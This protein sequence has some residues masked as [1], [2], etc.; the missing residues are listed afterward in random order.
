MS[1][2]RKTFE[3]GIETLTSPLRACHNLPVRKTD[4]RPE[5]AA[6]RPHKKRFSN[7]VPKKS[8]KKRSPKKRR[9]QPPAVGTQV[10]PD[11]GGPA[12]PIDAKPPLFGPPPSRRPSTPRK[13]RHSADTHV[14]LNAY[15]KQ[16]AVTSSADAKR[17]ESPLPDEVARHP[18]STELRTKGFGRPDREHS[19]VQEACGETTIFLVLKSGFLTKHETDA[20]RR[21]SPLVDHLI[22]TAHALGDYDFR[23]LRHPD[24]CW[25]SQTE[26]PAESKKAMLA[27]LFHY[28][29]DVLLLMR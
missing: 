18:T 2:M 15:E 1:V 4:A 10:H 17:G 5:H 19:A 11:E 27:C 29:L 13:R 28:D 9:R 12:P 3:P 21:T 6:P 14:D 24:T 22:R 25:A 7:H 16:F 8:R 23:W 20:V 26:I